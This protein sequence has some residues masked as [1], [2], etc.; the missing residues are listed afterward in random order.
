VALHVVV[1]AGGSGTRLWPLSRAAVPKHLLPIGPGGT[2]LLRATV[3]RALPLGGPVHVVTAAD[4]AEACRAALDGLPI[5]E[6]I[7]EPAARGTGPAL[8]LAV[9]WIARQD[10]DALIC[11]LHADHHI[12]DD[13]AYRAAVWAAAGWAAATDGLATVGLA[14]TYAST[15]FGYVALGAPRDAAAWSSP[16]PASQPELDAAAAA[17]PAHLS[18]GFVE[19]PAADVAAAYVAGGRHLWNLGLFA[20]PAAVFERELTAAA[21][22]VDAAVAHTVEG[23]GRGDEAEAAEAYTRLGT[24]AVEPLVLEQTSRLVVVR[25]SFPWSDLGS[26]VDLGDARR[27]LGAADM[28]GNLVDGDATLI[29]CSGCVVESRGGRHVAVVGATDLVVVDAGDSLLVVPAEHAQRVRDVV[30][31]LRAEGRDDLL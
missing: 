5:G 25:A 29:G 11:S 2:S 8:G 23:L 14:P 7:A 26:W 18:A 15:G 17:L 30:E 1:L 16:A 13:H 3:E 28:N 31:R 10:P 12:G 20:W 27:A 21:P 19:K 9:R 4:Q 22:E 6:V 24:I